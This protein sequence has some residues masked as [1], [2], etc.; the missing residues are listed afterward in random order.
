MERRRNRKRIEGEREKGGGG[1]VRES[2]RERMKWR[3]GKTT[4]ENI[5]ETLKWEESTRKIIQIEK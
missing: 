1:G 3:E 2:G 5:D 4:K